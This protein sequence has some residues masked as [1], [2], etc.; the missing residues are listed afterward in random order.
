MVLMRALPHL[1]SFRFPICVCECHYIW[2]QLYTLHLPLL[3][4]LAKQ[5]FFCPWTLFLSRYV[6]G[7]INNIGQTLRPKCHAAHDLTRP[8]YASTMYFNSHI[9][10]SMAPKYW[11]QD[12]M[13]FDRGHSVCAQLSIEEVEDKS[14]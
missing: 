6:I 10:D 13:C 12:R 1:C 9:I 4:L 7:G 8:H 14:C 5:H 11:W 3:V 2:K